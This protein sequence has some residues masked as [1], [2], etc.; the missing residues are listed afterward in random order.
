MN[1]TRRP[2]AQRGL[3]LVIVLVFVVILSGVAAFAVRRAMFGEHIARNVLDMEIARQAAEAA[4]R[5]AERDI[6][7]ADDVTGAACPRGDDRPIKSAYSEPNFGTDCPRGQCRFGEQTPASYYADSNAKS[8]TNPEPWW[9]ADSGGVGWKASPP[10]G[11]AFTGGV[12]LGTFTGTTGVKGVSRQPEYLIEYMQRGEEIYFR[13]TARGW[14]LD[15]N[16]E[17]V[18]QSYF[19][20]S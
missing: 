11:C 18:L 20:R 12:P 4:L 8:K 19:K 6:S 16:T 17:V 1:R 5:D 9:P 3:A 2:A 7:L 15:P 13:N 10:S 14:G